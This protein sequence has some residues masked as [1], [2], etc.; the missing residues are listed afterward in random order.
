M[1][2]L[3]QLRPALVMILAMT[4]VTGLAYPLTMTGI[5]K[6]MFP[7]QADG[8]LI[9]RNGQVVGSALIGQSFTSERYFHGRLSATVAPDP[10]DASKTVAAP[11]NAAN[12]GASNLAPTNK[13]LIERV[14][15][16]IEALRG[17]A[18]EP[19]AVPVP[20]DLVTS[21]ASGLDPHISPE[22]ALFQV[23]RI[24]RVRGLPAERIRALVEE[25]TEGRFL[26]ILGEPRVA[27]LGL[28]LALDALR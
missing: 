6:V 25:R 3:K 13:A 12:S 22:A 8:S 14:Q 17:E 19:P 20:M 11:Y 4:I 16:D 21:S 15:A 9:E 1:L 18:G 7:F 27:V 2:M 24:A 28:N 23:S 10:A 26:G 5:G